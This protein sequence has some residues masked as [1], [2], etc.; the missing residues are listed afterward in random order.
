[1]AGRDWRRDLSDG[2]CF[3][4]GAY[5]LLPAGDAVL[6]YAPGVAATWFAVSFGGTIELSVDDGATWVRR[7]ASHPDYVQIEIPN[8]LPPAPSRL[9]V[10]APMQSHPLRVY[11]LD[12]SAESGP[13]VTWFTSGV[14][15][16]RT[17]DLL[18]GLAANDER[19]FRAY[20]SM[21]ADL[22]TI[23]IGVNDTIHADQ[24][25]CDDS[26]AALRAILKG[27][28]RHGIGNLAL[29]GAC[30][31]R[32]DYQPGPWFISDAYER[33]YRPISRELGVPLLEWSRRWGDWEQADRRGYYADQ[34][35]PSRDGHW[36]AGAMIAGLLLRA[37]RAA[38]ILAAERPRPII[39]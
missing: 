2:G 7:E 13:S 10:R 26:A 31:V 6:S 35:H 36:D 37:E 22:L 16:A 38:S 1:M 17:R 34:V 12:H 39:R 5:E 8:P 28:A 21:K 11:S 9:Q 19:G 27:F 29:V 15:G 14:G 3:G 23:A 25:A 4:S 33:I 24:V 30:P 32:P 20:A 18:D